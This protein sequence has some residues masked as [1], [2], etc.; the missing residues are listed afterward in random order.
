MVTLACWLCTDSHRKQLRL[1]HTIIS[2]N[3]SHS[4]GEVKKLK[5]AS[6]EDKEETGEEDLKLNANEQEKVKE[7]YYCVLRKN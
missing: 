3:L 6:K 2:A 7:R 5:M 1:V 4:K